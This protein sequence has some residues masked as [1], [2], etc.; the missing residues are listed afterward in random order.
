MSKNVLFRRFLRN[1]VQVGALCPSS[2]A[3]CS[4]MVSEIGVDTADV[5]VEL[6]PGTGV[7]TREIVRCMSPNAKLIAIEL[8]QTLCVHLRK[9]FPE[10]TVCND[11][12]AGIGE[13]L[14]RHSLPNPDAVISG[15]PW[16]N[17]SSRLQRNILDAVAEHIAPGGY[18]TTFA[19]L[20]GLMFPNG[21]RFRRLLG[22]VF[23]EVEIS[24]V[25][26][27]NIPPAF[28]YRC[29]K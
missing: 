23:R 26:W 6:G 2:R 24:P 11:S 14:A 5:I 27:K 22:E 20:Q 4:T 28:V 1:P 8:D 29:R 25:V 21:Q 19:Y 7:I 10:V 17:F 12:A 18:F 9:A 15:L 13:I 3:L 16:A